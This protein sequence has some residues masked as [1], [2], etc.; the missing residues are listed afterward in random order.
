MDIKKILKQYNEWNDKKWESYFEVVCLLKK[1]GFWMAF[2]T[3]S[4]SKFMQLEWEAA[5]DMT[6]D[7]ILMGM[8]LPAPSSP[9]G[10]HAIVQ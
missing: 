5:D 8:P 6:Y 4:V 9:R 2:D 1:K 3:P 10:T 7:V